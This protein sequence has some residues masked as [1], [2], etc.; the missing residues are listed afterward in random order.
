MTVIDIDTETTGQDADEKRVIGLVEDLLREFPPRSTDP[1]VFLG[2]QYDKGLGW[3]HF[4]EGFGG[5]GL[6]PRLQ[7]TINERINAAGGPNPYY[8][9]PIGYGTCGPT[10]VEWGSDEQK[11]HFLRPLISGE[12]SGANSSRSPVRV[13]TSPVFP[14]AVSVTA[15]SGS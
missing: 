7:R 1:K 8:R 11:K 2:A 9:N 6:S 13:P 12:A 14:R 4:P 5:L 15:T 3:V 10:V